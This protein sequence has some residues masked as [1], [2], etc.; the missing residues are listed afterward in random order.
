MGS[1]KRFLAAFL[2]DCSSG[3]Q[4]QVLAKM[5]RRLRPRE[6][7]IYFEV[8]V[9]RTSDA[10]M[11]CLPECLRAF[12]QEPCEPNGKDLSKLSDR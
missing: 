8:L 4:Q 7:K 3:L 1:I 9:P 12:W 5:H 6:L 10:Y 11:D 2:E